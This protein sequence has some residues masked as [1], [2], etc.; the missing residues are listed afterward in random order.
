MIAT[1]RGKSGGLWFFPGM[2]LGPFGILFAAISAGRVCPYCRERVHPEAVK[3]PKCQSNIAQLPH[4]QEIPREPTAEELQ[5]AAE[6]R[7]TGR[8]GLGCVGRASLPALPSVKEGHGNHPGQEK[9]T[10]TSGALRAS[11]GNPLCPV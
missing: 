4:P 10:A 7:A 11:R 6:Q 9:L 1:K 5:R 8:H 2:L 3:C